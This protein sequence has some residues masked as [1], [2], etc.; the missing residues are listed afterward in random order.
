RGPMGIAEAVEFVAQA[1]AAIAE[2]HDVGV[3]H[4]DL[5][6]SNLFLTRR[7]DGTPCVKVLDF[8][9]SK[10]LSDLEA[11]TM[12]TALTSTR[13]VMGSPAYMSPEQVRDARNV[14][15]RTDVWALGVTLYELLTQRPAFDADTLPAV[16]AAIA[17]DPP[18]PLRERRAD[19]PEALEGIVL[20]CLEKQPAKRY[21]TARSLL[22]ALREFQGVAVEQRAIPS[23]RNAPT[24]QMSPSLS[25]GPSALRPG[26]AA[27][28]EESGSRRVITTGPV[29]SDG[30]LVSARTPP[31]GEHWANGASEPVLPP[32]SRGKLRLRSAFVSMLVI[33]VGVGAATAWFVR[34]RSNPMDGRV[35]VS[36]HPTGHF[37]LRIE[38]NP[39]RA[40]VLEAG[41]PIGVTPLTISMDRTTL[42]HTARQFL[43][44][45]DGF[46]DVTV[47]QPEASADVQQTIVLTPEVPSAVDDKS[48]SA[49]APT[50]T[51]R[52]TSPNPKRSSSKAKSA[53]QRPTASPEPEAPGIRG[54]R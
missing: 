41:N 43:V 22:E 54:T 51:A 18:V 39:S 12:Q 47:Q 26:E 20:R 30:T 11:A 15:H 42:R 46:R 38:S 2:A 50:E 27:R 45:K 36:S 33:L 32:V 44:H 53:P 31:S 6:P 52:P 23:E 8:G 28:F 3:V 16:C 17:A 4:R 49:T 5:K 1:T 9:I 13:Q 35:N 7:S 24:T 19:I 10:Q 37:V 14:D 29:A 21:A 48:T 34:N 40:L 25:Q